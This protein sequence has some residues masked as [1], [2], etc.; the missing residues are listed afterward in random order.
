MQRSRCT[1]PVPWVLP[2]TICSPLSG[3]ET[4]IYRLIRDPS[5][6]VERKYCDEPVMRSTSSRRK[7]LREPE[8]KQT[9]HE[10]NGLR[11]ILNGFAKQMRKPR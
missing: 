11:L 1:K 10:V 9:L 8:T 3:K 2:N 6:F 5:D 4:K 7:D